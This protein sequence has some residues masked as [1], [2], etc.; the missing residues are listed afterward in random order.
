[1]TAPFYFIS[2]SRSQLYFAESAAVELERMGIDVWFD[3]QQLKTGE[4][5]ASEIKRG[6]DECA[7]VVLIVSQRSLASKYV[8]LEWKAALDAGK[9]VYLLYFEPAE[10]TDE[11]LHHCPAIDGRGRF[12][13]AIRQMARAIKQEE[14]P[15]EGARFWTVRPPGRLAR[16]LAADDDGAMRFPT[17]LSPGVLLITLSVLGI[18]ATLFLSMLMAWAAFGLIFSLWLAVL[19]GYGVL[20]SSHY[21]RRKLTQE[22]PRF[23]V[24]VSLLGALA[25]LLMYAQY[26]ERQRTMA[27]FTVMIAVLTLV[28]ILAYRLR[29]GDVLRWTLTGFAG[30]RRRRRHHGGRWLRRAGTGDHRVSYRV[31][32]SR[33]DE[34]FAMRLNKAMQKYKHVPATDAADRDDT[35]DFFLVSNVTVWDEV[36]AAAAA[37]PRLIVAAMTSVKLPDDVYQKIGRFQ[38]LD[39][40]TDAKRRFETMAASLTETEVQ[41]NSLSA[42]LETTPANLDLTVIPVRVQTGLGMLRMYAIT[43]LVAPVLVVLQLITD[44]S[45]MSTINVSVPVLVLSHVMGLIFALFCFGLDHLARSRQITR[46]MFMIVYPVGMLLYSTVSSAIGGVQILEREQASMPL[47]F[48]IS[49]GIVFL[50]SAGLFAW[51]PAVQPRALSFGGVRAEGGKVARDVVLISAAATYGTFAILPVLS[52]VGLGAGQTLGAMA[53]AEAATA[54]A[55]SSYISDGNL[56]V[57]FPTGVRVVSIESG[58]LD[59]TRNDIDPAMMTSLQHF[60]DGTPTSI[61]ETFTP[62]YAAYSIDSDGYTLILLGGQFIVQA[63]DEHPDYARL[64]LEAQ[65]TGFSEIDDLVYEPEYV[66]GTGA[67]SIPGALMSIPWSAADD[68]PIMNHFAAIDTVSAHHL[69]YIV[70]SADASAQTLVEQLFALIVAVD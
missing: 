45:S 21:V 65:V 6:L 61:D 14:A 35:Y 30:E 11:R 57:R 33:G 10:L 31:M 43:G 20:A 8:E 69:I 44:H 53:N 48:A 26:P 63:E 13:Q 40:R 49:M 12:K 22:P 3:L 54:P 42:S 55:F 15:Q 17:K 56:M 59:A 70:S 64:W 38:Y 58:K 46:Q 25:M 9:P 29:S 28:F 18:S 34:K 7:G 19:A 16:I 27:I 36:R 39:A 1:M 60:V 37:H 47:T 5:W 24:L 62:T 67:Q 41:S 52:L 51:L 23:F 32:H 4:D 66:F 50:T 68:Q 2:Y